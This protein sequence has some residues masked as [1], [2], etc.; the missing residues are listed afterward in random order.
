MSVAKA[1]TL[2]HAR[3]Y[4]LCEM[5]TANAIPVVHTRWTWTQK[6]DKLP[7]EPI[8]FLFVR[9]RTKHLGATVDFGIVPH[10]QPFNIY[11]KRKYA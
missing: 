7:I 6:A 2:T 4:W 8:E 1:H 5:N 11:W 9:L 10:V 3:H